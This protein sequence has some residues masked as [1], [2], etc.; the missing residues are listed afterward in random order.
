MPRNAAALRL[1]VHQMA[2]QEPPRPPK[3]PRATIASMFGAA[4]SRAAS[5]RGAAGRLPAKRSRP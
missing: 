2:G 5:G 1:L 3:A 4:A